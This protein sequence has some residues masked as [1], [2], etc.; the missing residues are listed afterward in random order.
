LHGGSIAVDSV[1]GEGTT[2]TVTLPAG[3]AHLPAERITA[4]RRAELGRVAAHAFVA[5][6]A[7]WLP[8]ST[9]LATPSATV[10]AATDSARIVLADDNADMRSYMA[11]L[12]GARW[13]V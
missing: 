9:D 13:Q 11:R 8:D 12:L 1:E 2:F 10:A 6:A 7:R 3:S 5:E 4:S